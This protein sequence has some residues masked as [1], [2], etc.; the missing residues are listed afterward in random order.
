MVEGRGRLVQA[1][2]NR[3][4]SV[5]GE[6]VVGPYRTARDDLGG[7]SVADVLGLADDR[8]LGVDLGTVT[9]AR[10][11][12]VAAGPELALARA[13]EADRS[14]R[15]ADRVRES[16]G[17]PDPTV[18]AVSATYLNAHLAVL[19]GATTGSGGGLLFSTTETGG[20]A[21]RAGTLRRPFFGSDQAGRPVDDRVETPIYAD[22]RSP[23]LAV[24]APWRRDDGRLR[25]P[26]V[27]ELLADFHVACRDT[28]A[29]NAGGRFDVVA[30]LPDR[31][32][33]A[34][35]VTVAEL[36]RLVDGVRAVAAEHGA[37][38]VWVVVDGAQVR[39]PSRAAVGDPDGP[40][41][42]YGR[43]GV[44]V[45][46]VMWTTSKGPGGTPFAAGLTVTQSL[47]DA[48]VEA[49]AA[50]EP[51][52]PTAGFA[53]GYLCVGDLP[54]RVPAVLAD[55]AVAS[56]RHHARL[57]RDLSRLR[58]WSALDASVLES[59]RDRLMR[60]LL[61]G[62]HVR[63]LPESTDE[64]VAAMTLSGLSDSDA[65]AVISLL[66]MGFDARAALGSA[67]DVEQASGLL[68]TPC[69]W[70]V[71]DHG[72]PVL[73]VAVPLELADPPVPAADL[74]RLG[75]VLA[76]RFDLIIRALPVLGPALAATENSRVTAERAAFGID[77]GP[78]G[79]HG[80]PFGGHGGR[81]A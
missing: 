10:M 30:L 13:D 51:T 52:S 39:G 22:G 44:D 21:H 69:G 12:V 25:E 4:L 11:P 63:L 72:P 16:L 6:D 17:W 20:N 31:P 42:W 78:F 55:R 74:D 24:N 64:S 80:G 77:G 23:A 1:W 59:V 53:A 66:R 7:R 40:V 68:P 36:G 73:R 45:D 47:R 41:R 9:A 70:P 3:S 43:H 38:R 79:G 50:A 56:A 15:L 19:A 46:G 32:K 37:G 26:L 54:G 35:A 8:L 2:L 28:A 49:L 62:G 14:S 29:R 75:Q 34:V 76:T 61:E 33:T 18:L 57:L 58:R 81:E 67:S 71:I 65:D 27:E 60:P 48:L 5:V